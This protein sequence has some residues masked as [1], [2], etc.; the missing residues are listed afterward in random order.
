MRVFVADDS[1]ALREHLISL[2]SE[3]P[4][5]EVVGQ[6]QDT[7]EAFNALCRFEPHVVILDIQ[8]PGGNGIK[9][10][11]KIKR[12]QPAIIVMMLTHYDYP[13]YRRKCMEYGA[14]FFF[15]KAQDYKK[16]KETFTALA[17]NFIAIKLS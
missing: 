5:L 9:V 8:M 13:Q 4:G 12:Q 2:L 1:A 14:D 15:D 6:A 17:E 16:I 3:I 11:Q 10:L 7:P